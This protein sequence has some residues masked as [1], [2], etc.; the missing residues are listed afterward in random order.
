MCVSEYKAAM[1]L[2]TKEAKGEKALLIT[3]PTDRAAL[4]LVRLTAF[5]LRL[6]ARV[7]AHLIIN[8]LVQHSGREGKARTH[9]MCV[10]RENWVRAMLIAFACARLLI[11][12]KFPCIPSCA[13]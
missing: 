9:V 4:V 1:D 8:Q 11:L 13:R 10:G 6:F 2:K 5:R 7:S 12:Q 3:P